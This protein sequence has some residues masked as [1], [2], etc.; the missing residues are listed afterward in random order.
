MIYD[1]FNSYDEDHNGHL[2]EEEF[3]K[4]VKLNTLEGYA[5]FCPKVDQPLP[6]NYDE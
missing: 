4:V 5:K 6:E 3:L 1:N 2:N